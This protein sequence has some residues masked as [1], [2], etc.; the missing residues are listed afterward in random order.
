MPEYVKMKYSL[1]G[2]KKKKKKVAESEGWAA[3]GKRKQ[4]KPMG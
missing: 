2:L 4:V 1:P 3:S